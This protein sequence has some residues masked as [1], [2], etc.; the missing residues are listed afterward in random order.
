MEYSAPEKQALSILGR[1]DFK[2]IKK[3]EIL[4]IT[5]ML[6]NFRPEVALEA[7]KLPGTVKTAPGLYK[8]V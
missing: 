2:S 5:S 8:R 4:S 1:T 3:D 6:C 7:I